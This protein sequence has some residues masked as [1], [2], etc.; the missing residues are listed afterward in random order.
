MEIPPE[1]VFEFC[2]PS[3]IKTLPLHEPPLKCS[4]ACELKSGLQYIKPHTVS[5]LISG[6]IQLNTKF[7]IIDCRWDY[8]YTGGHIGNAVN[9]F[10]EEDMVS[11]FFENPPQCALDEK[12]ILIFHCEFSSYRAPKM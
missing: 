7:L 9:I 10:R 1:S 3:F 11:F 6:E 2:P 8:E 5:Q 12:I 4:L